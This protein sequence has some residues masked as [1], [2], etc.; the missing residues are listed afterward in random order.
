MINGIAFTGRETM[1][2][3]PAAKIISK[4]HEYVAASKIYPTAEN[5]TK[6]AAK[7]AAKSIAKA[8]APVCT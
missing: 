2:T 8:P 4:A 5:A 1:L 6:E 7:L 3:E